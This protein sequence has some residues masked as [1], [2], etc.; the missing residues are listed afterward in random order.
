MITLRRSQ[1]RAQVPGL[2]KDGGE[3]TDGLQAKYKVRNLHCTFSNEAFDTKY[4]GS[5]RRL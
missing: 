1:V 2:I 4:K 5:V 3:K